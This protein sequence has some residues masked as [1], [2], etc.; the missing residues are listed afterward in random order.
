MSTRK[1]SLFPLLTGIALISPPLHAEE[2]YKQIDEKGHVTYS[3]K[4]IKGGKKVDLP[5]LS[6]F[7]APKVVNTNP[8]SKE[9]ADKNQRRSD[10]QSDIAK[11][12]KALADAKQAYKEAADQP[13]LWVNSKTV[14]GP[15]GK[16]KV[17]TA[18]GR[19]VAAY[20]EKLKPL[21]AEVNLHE[22]KLQQ[23]KAELASL[24]PKKDDKK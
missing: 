21:Q 6:T 18:S 7:K 17:V 2:I 23:L 9:N 3:N 15:D 8:A 10:L 22:E 14:T 19:N 24:D 11:E 4:P 12:E 1:R 16:P 5:E 13:E 20:E